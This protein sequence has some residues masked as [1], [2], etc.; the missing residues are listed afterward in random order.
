MTEL[1]TQLTQS[2]LKFRSKKKNHFQLLISTKVIM[3]CKSDLTRREA[4]CYVLWVSSSEFSETANTEQEGMLLGERG[5]G[6]TKVKDVK[7]NYI[8]FR[9]H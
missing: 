5:E 7:V 2:G 3:F 4:Y 6:Y 1:R 8:N 9:E